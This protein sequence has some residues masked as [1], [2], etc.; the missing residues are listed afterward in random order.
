MIHFSHDSAFQP[1]STILILGAF[2]LL[3]MGGTGVAA[4][5]QRR[6]SAPRQGNEDPP[7]FHD[8]R[9]IEIGMLADD[10]RKK[11][12]D[13]ANKGDDQDFFVFN[14]KETFQ[15]VYDKLHKV[16]TLSIDFTNG[17]NGVPT[18]KQ[19]LGSDIAAKADGS[20]YRM[21]RYPKAG[22][23]L[24]YSRTAGD[25]PMVSVTLQKIE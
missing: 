23:W 16:T 18:A 8:Y 11:L 6:A 7:V 4:M 9:G 22:Y 25:S 12:G 1:V 15:I 3:L 17:A 5:G 2:S 24:S 10:V 20:M 14:E 19:V 21:V 13:P